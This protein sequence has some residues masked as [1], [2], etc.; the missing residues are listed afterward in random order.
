MHQALLL[1]GMTYVIPSS[2]SAWCSCTDVVWHDCATPMLG[3]IDAVWHSRATPH[4]SRRTVAGL[5][6]GT[7][8]RLV[9][10]LLLYC[11]VGA[12]RQRQLCSATC[13]TCIAACRIHRS[14]VCACSYQYSYATG[15]ACCCCICAVVVY[16]H[17]TDTTTAYHTGSYW[18]DT[19][20]RVSI[21]VL[22]C[23]GCYVNSIHCLDGY[24]T[25]VPYHPSL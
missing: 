8:Y 4:P 22:C 12:V 16:D 19:R 2:S 24:G 1:D 3:M 18:I 15:M 20:T 21:H 6:A 25:T 13:C 23:D 17:C 7:A 5:Y 10:L 14:G 11:T 9:Q